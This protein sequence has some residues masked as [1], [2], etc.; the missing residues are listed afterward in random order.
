MQLG[1]LTL[2]GNGCFGSSNVITISGDEGRYAFP[3]RAKLNKKSDTSFDRKTCNLRLPIAVAPNE[4]VQLIDLSQVVRVV[5][6][7]GAQVKTNLNMGFAGKTTPPLSYNLDVSD[8]EIS[9]AEILKS[10][11]VLVESECGKDA[12]LTGNLSLLVNGTG[13]QAFVSTGTALLTLKV[14]SCNH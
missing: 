12:M 14:V 1:A 4:K 2:A 7:K 5:A 9:T 8:D 11:G 3:I 10:P 13:A 6:Y